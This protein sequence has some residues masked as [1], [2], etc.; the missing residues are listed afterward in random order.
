MIVY[1]FA[2][3]SNPQI[4]GFRTYGTVATVKEA[5][6]ALTEKINSPGKVTFG[7]RKDGKFRAFVDGVPTGFMYFDTEI[8]IAVDGEGNKIASGTLEQCDKQV[9]KFLAKTFGNPS[10]KGY[11]IKSRNYGKGKKILYS[12]IY[13]GDK[14]FTPDAIVH[15]I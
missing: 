6:K 4:P 7:L 14:H 10:I 11:T 1:G 2:Y 5:E 13:P 15:R 9:K 12:S 8:Y 3:A